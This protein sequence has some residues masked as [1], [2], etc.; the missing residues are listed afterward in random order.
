MAGSSDR[1]SELGGEET[2][3][4]PAK[5][6]ERAAT[7]ISNASEPGPKAP[8]IAQTSNAFAPGSRIN[9]YELIRPI[10]SGGMGDVF[11]ARDTKLGRRVAIKVIQRTSEAGTQ[12]FLR[13]ARATAQCNHENIV[14]IHEVNEIAG[15]PYMVL[16][17]LEGAPLSDL[18]DQGRIA[19]HRTVELMIPVVRA[20]ARAHEFGIVHRDLKPDNVLLASSG[21][22]KVLDF[23]IAKAFLDPDQPNTSPTAL[24]PGSPLAKQLTRDDAIV[25]TLPYMSPEQLGADTVDHRSDLWAAGIMMFEMLLGAH[26]LAPYTPADIIEVRQLDSPMP[27]VD[28]LIAG[29]PAELGGIVERCLAKRKQDRYRD[30]AELLADLEALLPGQRRRLSDADHPYPGLVA[31]QESDADR[32]FGRS[33]E[34][35]QVV[36]WIRDRPLT[37]IAG[38]SGAGKSSFV[39]AGVVPALKA[40]GEAWEVFTLRP[41]RQPLA[42]LASLLQPLTRT[43]AGENEIA[44]HEALVERLREQPGYLGALLRRRCR[45]RETLALLYVDQFEELYTLVPDVEERLAFTR[46]LSG[47]ADDS[48]TPLRVVVSTRSDFLDRVAEDRRFVEDL[49]RG[50]FFLPPPDR[51]GLRAAIV[52]PAQMAGFN[53]ED[54]SIVDEMIEVLEATPGAL[55]LL[56][57]AAAKLWEARDR[58]RKSITTQSYHD[59]GGVE[60]ALAAHADQVLAELTAS[61]RKLVRDIF[62]RLVTPDRTRAV[63]GQRELASLSSESG[64]VDRL[65]ARL[66]EAR[67]LLVHS[68]EESEGSQVELVHESLIATWPTLRRWLDES[69]EDAAFVSELQTVAKQWDQRGRAGGL[70]WSGEAADEAERWR[71]RSQAVLTGRE[72]D[73]L[74]AVLQLRTRAAKRRRIAVVATIVVLAVM[75]AG[76]AGALFVIS[77]AKQQAQH[78]SQTARKAEKQVAS[79]L[80]QLKAKERARLAAERQ[81]STATLKAKTAEKQVKTA[82][83]QVKTAEKQVETA[84]TKATKATAEVAQTKGQLKV[85]NKNLRRA[86]QKAQD[87]AKIADKES[88]RAR[89]MAALANTERK[90]AEALAETRRKQLL[91]QKRKL[92]KYTGGDDL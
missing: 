61:G 86:L 64:E 83:K 23:G 78:E 44:E 65:L 34:V 87:A 71:A 80:E 20:L 59:L 54:G 35:A 52:E 21:T 31:F 11:L 17:F 33:R 58:G 16:E 51:E 10:G 91:E 85:S 2:F 88:K 22:V 66:T 28:E 29:V 43:A 3:R 70:V 38:Q 40:S 13:E 76:A 48:S 77:G 8:S 15:T 74:D 46:C 19:S 72:R 32:F 24:E 1:T 30:A 67:L 42:A 90:R 73:Y 82:E 4:V 14:V 47:V 37:A 27:T 6:A 45:E 81:A 63:V 25:G 84:T 18:V 36:K 41:G 12:R 26:P 69:S 55:P 57:F 50:L 79:Q 39:R 75:V 89:D 9:H 60:G 53:F 49:T 68:R 62:V 7:E 92:R 5:P 56:Q